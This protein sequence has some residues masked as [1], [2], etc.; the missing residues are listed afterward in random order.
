[1]LR[2]E[3]GAE[4]DAEVVQLTESLLSDAAVAFAEGPP[5]RASVDVSVPEPLPIL[6]AAQPLD[7]EVRAPEPPPPT[8]SGTHAS[9]AFVGTPPVAANASANANASATRVARARWAP[10]AVAFAATLLVIGTVW[11]RRAAR[12]AT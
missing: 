5:N 7:P 1:M 12:T 8:M 9:A 11:T 2:A 4:P 10:L 3:F 6:G